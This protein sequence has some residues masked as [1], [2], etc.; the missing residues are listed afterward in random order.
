MDGMPKED[1]MSRNPEWDAA[2]DV[3]VELHRLG[4]P[5]EL[6][7]EA[8]AVRTGFWPDTGKTYRGPRHPVKA[9]WWK[10]L[11]GLA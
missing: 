1:N 11:L 7:R 9:P 5:T 2:L 8:F 10:R 6:A 3:A 4:V